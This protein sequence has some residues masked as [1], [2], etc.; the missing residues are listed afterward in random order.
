MSIV[1]SARC[2]LSSTST[3]P[4]RFS[5][6]SSSSRLPFPAVRSY[7][8]AGGEKDELVVKLQSGLKEAMRAKDK[9]RSQVLKV[10]CEKRLHFEMHVALAR[11]SR[12][13]FPRFV[14]VA[15]AKSARGEGRAI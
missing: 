6:S 8:T 5:S 11:S 3:R 2:L 15:R 12:R 13:F 1:P 7:A 4:I 9:F 14:V 10:S